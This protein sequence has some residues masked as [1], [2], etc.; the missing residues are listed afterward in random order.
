MSSR[1]WG[2][3][4]VLL[5]CLPAQAQ[6]EA[7]LR[8]GWEALPE[9]AG[10]IY[11]RRQG[12][13]RRL[14][15][16]GAREAAEETPGRW[17]SLTVEAEP[18]YPVRPW[19]S[20]PANHTFGARL[21]LRLGRQGSLRRAAWRAEARALE[22]LA[23][24]ERME[25]T[26]EVAEAWA[27]WSVASGVL[28]HFAQDLEEL[29]AQ[30]EPLRAG[31]ARGEYPGQSLREQETELAWLRA[32]LARARRAE[33]SARHE[34]EALLLEDAALPEG[35][36]L[37]GYS[38]PLADPWGALGE[39]LEGHP[40]LRWLREAGRAQEAEAEAAGAGEPWRL[41]LGGSAQLDLAGSAWGTVSVGLEIPLSS[42]GAPEAARR[43]AEARALGWQGESEARRL[44]SWWRGQGRVW[45]ADR[46]QLVAL[47][48]ELLG[49]L[50]ARLAHLREGQGR[51]EVTLEQVLR[52]RRELHEAHHQRLEVVSSL[53]LHNVRARA[54]RRA[55]GLEEET[56]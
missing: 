24:W 17:E 6:E 3:L 22:A 13:A 11:D 46:A 34:V 10:R 20:N 51:Q 25:F 55:L 53:W 28:E 32:E 4:C 56:R 14:E 45:E 9:V 7:A 18:A 33:V 50:E 42:E 36:P 15:A 52:V 39:G 48:E 2:A 37:E 5:W 30:L 54:L 29:S 8:L 49:P 47:E 44:R 38:P 31:E 1:W 27:S 19:R 40:S 21:G 35:A 23:G 12:A 41:V 43:G 16:E 26:L